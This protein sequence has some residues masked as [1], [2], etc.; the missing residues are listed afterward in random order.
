IEGC[1]KIAGERSVLFLKWDNLD[2]AGQKHAKPF[3]I[4]A[5]VAAAR[6]PVAK[7]EQHDGRRCDG[8]PPAQGAPQPFANDSRLVLEQSDDDAG[9]EQVV[10]SN[11]FLGLGIGG[12]L[13]PSS[14]NGISAKRSRAA[15]Q[16]SMSVAM[17]SSRIPS[18]TR[19]T[20]TRSPGKRNAIGS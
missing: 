7:L 17:G 1:T 19:R 20:R 6:D 3:F 14:M 13:R 10:H 4:F 11:I 16:A 5:T 8:R 18:L 15:N 2:P 9:V 12:C